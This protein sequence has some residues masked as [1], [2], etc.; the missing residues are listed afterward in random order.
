MV[1]TFAGYALVFFGSIPAVLFT[2]DGPLALIRTGQDL[3][4]L[5]AMV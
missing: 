4:F 3:G 1:V 5:G 2:Q